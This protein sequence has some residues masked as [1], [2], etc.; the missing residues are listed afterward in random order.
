VSCLRLLL[1]LSFAIL[2]V[3]APA[4]AAVR[5]KLNLTLPPAGGD[6][7]VPTPFSWNIQHKRPG[8]VVVQRQVGTLGSWRTIATLRGTSG[9]GTIPALPLGSYSLRI[10]NLGPR[11]KHTHRYR[12]WG[13]QLRELR[14]FGRVELG[15]LLHDESSGVFSTPTNTFVWID[16]TSPK[17]TPGEIFGFPINYCRSVHIDFVTDNENDIKNRPATTGTVT[18]L[19]E[20]ADPVSMT[21]AE[22][23][24]AG[25]DANLVPGKGWSMAVSE[26]GDEFSVVLYYNGWANCYRTASSSVA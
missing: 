9:T 26:A 1:A 15:T 22:D 20:T 10:A 23:T 7:G 13:R 3:S 12:E 18:I 24:I 4:D 2:A 11:I 19:Q 5:P 8:I 21:A 14:I 25:V 17:P 16:R 6:A